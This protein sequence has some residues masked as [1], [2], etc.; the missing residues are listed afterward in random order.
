MTRIQS[1]Q[2]RKTFFA[3]AQVKGLGEW[4]WPAL[5][6]RSFARV[7][8]WFVK[9][10][11]LEFEGVPGQ[12]QKPIIPSGKVMM[13]FIKNILTVETISILQSVCILCIRTNAI[14]LN[15]GHRRDVQSTRLG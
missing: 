12:T 14:Q 15:R 7:N 4:V 13:E 1:F 11:D 8:S 6:S 10:T 2:P 5:S 3:R 9:K